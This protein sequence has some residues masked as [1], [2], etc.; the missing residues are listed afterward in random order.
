MNENLILQNYSDFLQENTELFEESA[1][2]ST[3]ITDTMTYDSYTNKL[4]EGIE[5]SSARTIRDMFDRQRTVLL[6]ESSSLMGTSEGITYAVASFPMLVDLYADPLLSKVVSVYPSTVPT[7]SIPRL[8]WVSKIIDIKGNATE[9]EFPNAEKSIRVGFETVTLGQFGNV[10]D[11]ALGDDLKSTKGEFRLNKRNFKMTS[12]TVTVA[13]E[14]KIVPVIAVADARGHFVAE[15]IKV[16]DVAGTLFKV[17]GQINF[18]TGDVTWNVINLEGSTETVVAKEASLRM[19]IQGVGNAKGVVK[20]RPKQDI[21]DINCDIEDSFEI[22]NIE[23][24]IQDWKSLYNLDIMAQLKNYVKDQIKLNRD[25][26]I[27]EILESNVPVCKQNGLFREVD[28]SSVASATDTK[29]STV[30]DIFRNLVPVLVS[31][32]ES[33]RKKTR[34][35]VKYLVTG[36]DGA[37]ILK[38]LQSFAVSMDKMEGSVGQAGDS[39]GSF[40]KLEVISSFAVGDDYIYLIPKA[41]SLSQATLVEIS[42]KPLYV[43]VETTNSIKRTFIKC[44]NWIGLVRNEAIATIHLKGY[45]AALGQA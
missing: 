10:F 3:I 11:K 39:V 37:A 33:L 7:M 29:P 34:M 38:S 9:F 40:N 27:A 41:E 5:E 20:A 17:A 4:L 23:E 19:R 25:F 45:Q 42:H 15:D 43:I 6:E 24:V 26:E 35:E 14:D 18:E 1:S 31:L 32:I 36:I 13:G 12:V 44:R 16:D 22:E 30:M 8:K 21:L 28:F 2:A